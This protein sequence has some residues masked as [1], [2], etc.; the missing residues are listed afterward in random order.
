MAT[1]IKLPPRLKARVASAAKKAGKSPHA[2]MLE[3]IEQGTTSAERR[4]R[5]V[6][7]AL[8]AEVET[9]GTGQGFAADEVF[10]YL[11]ARARGGK[12]RRPRAKPWRG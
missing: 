12:P 10:R 2:F 9:R 11:E 7:D 8:A 1:S 3:A 5:F 4:Q 6:A